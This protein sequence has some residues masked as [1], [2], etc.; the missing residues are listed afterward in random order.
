MISISFDTSTISPNP[1]N[2]D[3]RE[4]A[5]SLAIKYNEPRV[6]SLLLTEEE[7]EE[8]EEEGTR[9]SYFI[10][11][12]EAARFGN[13]DILKQILPKLKT[14]V[15]AI[16]LEEGVSSNSP[17]VVKLILPLLVCDID[18]LDPDEVYS[19]ARTAAYIND[20]S[21]LKLLMN[22]YWDLDLSDSI[23]YG[24]MI[25][26]HR[27]L[28]EKALSLGAT[29]IS[30][31]LQD[32]AGNGNLEMLLWYFQQ[33]GVF[34]DSE[35]YG[36]IIKSALANRHL[37]I[38]RMMFDMANFSKVPLNAKDILQSTDKFPDDF[39][40]VVN[41]FRL[42]PNVLKVKEKDWET[43]LRIAVAHA[44]ANRTYF[45]LATVQRHLPRDDTIYHIPVDV[46]TNLLS[47]AIHSDSRSVARYLNTL[48]KR[49]H[50]S[51]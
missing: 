10:L 32:V 43:T 45:D 16:I 11:G 40:F 33:Y 5:F 2:D 26:C 17:D 1:L 44:L 48:I 38:V 13:V 12:R 7:E 39:D 23:F 25:G 6:I 42:Y 18:K 19:L 15:L 36:N 27:K 50:V 9:Y 3:E 41:L 8:E 34:L 28:A 29:N 46:L 4:K 22:L 35:A 37:D 51:S 21:L 47:R 14:D 24:A 20:V 49:Y 30:S 31:T